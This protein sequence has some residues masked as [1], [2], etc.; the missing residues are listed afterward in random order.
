VE[1]QQNEKYGTGFF[2]LNI[3]YL[4]LKIESRIMIA[5]TNGA[6]LLLA[7]ENSKILTNF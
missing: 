3:K 2:A 7:L 1:K 4:Q 6:H 5:V